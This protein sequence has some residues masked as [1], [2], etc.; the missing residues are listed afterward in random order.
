[1]T[2][3]K[4]KHF[5]SYMSIPIGDHTGDDCPPISDL[6]RFMDGKSS[7]SERKQITRRLNRCRSCYTFFSEALAI[8]EELE[9]EKQVSPNG[10][11]D[12]IPR[13]L[14]TIG[15]SLIPA[16]GRPVKTWLSIPAL[17]VL[18]LAVFTVFKPYTPPDYGMLVSSVGD[19]QVSN[20]LYNQLKT[21]QYRSGVYGFFGGLSLERAAFRVG[22][23]TYNL[24]ITLRAKDVEQ[25]LLVLTPL[26]SI[27]REIDKQGRV[28]AE[29]QTAMSRLEKGIFPESISD[30]TNKIEPLLQ[31][32]QVA[33]F[34]L[35]GV[36]ARGGNLAAA[37]E[38]ASF[39]NRRDLKY[40]L[41][42]T[43][44]RGFPPGVSDRLESIDQS[45]SLNSITGNAFLKIKQDF[46]T[47]M[48]I[49]M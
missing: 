4:E 34:M 40:Y 45:L 26:V 16:P 8:N 31:R 28:V 2:K 48:Q 1:M 23:L 11:W 10:S 17:V 14:K 27:L 15:Q 39:F 12:A 6:S 38:D 32:R 5:S 33:F 46:E 49:L 29:F 30:H 36:W 43:Q 7:Y 35:F 42:E 47:I 19:A 20:R 3:N 37:D 24:E 22:V 44:I 13:F 21:Q 25:S 41:E 9:A 18:L